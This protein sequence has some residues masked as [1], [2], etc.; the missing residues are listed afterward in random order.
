MYSL[1]FCFICDPP[2]EVQNFFLRFKL[3]IYNRRIERLLTLNS[4]RKHYHGIQVVVIVVLYGRMKYS[5]LIHSNGPS[6]VTFVW[7][8][9]SREMFFMKNRRT[10][11]PLLPFYTDLIGG[12]REDTAVTF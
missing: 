4:F 11:E 6:L 1:H 5:P 2:G 10:W 7:V 8:K 3:I 12:R 9:W